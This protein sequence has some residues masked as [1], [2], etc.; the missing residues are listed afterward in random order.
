MLGFNYKQNST[1]ILKLEGMVKFSTILH[2]LRRDKATKKIVTMSVPKT[3]A[4]IAFA[5]SLMTSAHAQL[6][7]SMDGTGNN[8]SNPEFG[9]TH[10]PM[11]IMTSLDYSNGINSP[12]GWNRANARAVSNEIFASIHDQVDRHGLSSLVWAFGK[13]IEHDITYFEHDP[14][15]RMY[16]KVPNC[17]KFLDPNCSG[18]QNLVFTRIKSLEGTGHSLENPRNVAN[19]TTAYIDAS[20]I[21]GSNEETSNW[22][23]TGVNGKLKVSEGNM[24]PFNTLDGEL[25]GPT[26]PDAPAIHQPLPGVNRYFVSG[27]P[28]VNENLA[29][30]SLHTLFVREHNRICDELIRKSPGYTDEALYQKA[31]SMVAGIIQSIVYNEWLP[32]IGIDLG[33]Y[34]G[35]NQFVDPA[36]SNEFC[37]AGFK[38]WNTVMTKEFDLLDDFCEPHQMGQWSFNDLMYNPLQ[39]LKTNLSPLLKGMAQQRQ[40]DMDCEVIDEIR[41]FHYNNQGVEIKTDW[42]TQD[43]MRGRERG[44]PDYN[45]LRNQLGLAPIESFEEITDDPGVQATLR[46]VYNNDLHNIDAWVGMVAERRYPNAILGETMYY[47]LSDQ[48]RRLRRGDRFYYENDPLLTYE[49]TEKIHHTT[50]ADVIKRNTDLQFLQD[51]IFKYD[52]HCLEIDIENSH[53]SG[54]VFPNPVANE[55]GLSVYSLEAGPATMNI[56]GALGKVVHTSRIQLDKG[57]NLMHTYLQDELPSGFYIVQIVKNNAVGNIKF[58]KSN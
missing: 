7:R 5:L 29:I 34:K 45:S 31:R 16:V 37:A 17:D 57:V 25:N 42:I 15:D 38:I 1:D 55:M 40:L 9:A 30:L 18:A 13:F 41:N 26:D 46:K 22:L 54:Q 27:D 49:D 14:D 19:Y 47:L 56:I 21:Y 52:P 8:I 2:T 6:Y 12:A 10:Q 3:L 11:R 24:L 50:L 48:F 51:N 39:I 44:I 4:C 23:R 53:L 43:I 58:V 36:I 20:P 28:R 32:A 35:Y 33:E